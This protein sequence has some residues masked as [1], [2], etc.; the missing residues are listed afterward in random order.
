[1]IRRFNPKRPI[2]RD[3]LIELN[4]RTRRIM[5]TLDQLNAAV[6]AVSDSVAKVGTDVQSAIAD[7]QALQSQTGGIKPTDLDAVVANLG[8]IATTLGSTSTALEAVLPPP[9]PPPAPPTS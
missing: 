9:T 7:I 5:A 3:L 6:Q 1:M 4:E 2:A 8:T